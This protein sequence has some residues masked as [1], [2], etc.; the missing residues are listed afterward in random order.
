MDRDCRPSRYSRR[1]VLAAGFLAF[2]AAP[3]LQACAGQAPPAPTPVPAPAAPPTPQPPIEVTRVVTQ[4]VTQVV[5]KQVTQIVEVTKAVPVQVTVVA[6]EVSL[7]HIF[8]TI[9]DQ[10]KAMKAVVAEFEKRNPGILVTNNEVQREDIKVLAPSAMR[11]SKAPDVVQYRVISDA[12]VGYDAGLCMDLSDLWKQNNWE[13]EFGPLSANAKWKGKY[14][15]IPW[16]IDSFPGYWYITEDWQKRGFKDPTDFTSLETILDTYKKDNVSPLVVANIEKWHMPYQIEYLILGIGG[17]KT[18][19]GLT[20][21]SVKWTDDL[22]RQ[23]F[24]KAAD[25]LKKG[26]FYP[27]M[28]A[29][30]LE[31]IFPFWLSGKGALIPGGAWVVTAAESQQKHSDYFRPPTLSV[32]VENAV[33]ASTEPFSISA[34]AE[35]PDEAKLLLSFMASKDAQQIFGDIALNPMSNGHVDVSHLPPAV[36]HNLKDV[37]KGPV[38]LGFDWDLPNPVY[39]QAWAGIQQLVGSPDDA[40]ITKVLTDIQKVATDFFK[41]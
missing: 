33:T 12:R 22:V 17:R 5:E 40:T 3:L 31:D 8:S 23:S 11:T 25:W 13:Q 16:N 14:W 24:A 37:Q 29:Y 28:N 39:T 15:N 34:K 20:D 30:K 4:V 10:E 21:G 19:V 6:K 2:G 18:W 27:N 26:Y 1:R 7:W 36:Q 38:V 35:H 32:D 9:G 41:K